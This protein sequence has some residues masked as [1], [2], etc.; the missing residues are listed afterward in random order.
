[1]ITQTVFLESPPEKV[2]D[3]L[4]NEKKHSEFIGANA[5]IEQKVNGSFS[6]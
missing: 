6:V 4:M 3:C 1:M 2:Y 5:K